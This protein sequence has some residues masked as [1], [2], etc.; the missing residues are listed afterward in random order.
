MI[1]FSQ[2]DVACLKE[3]FVWLA[4]LESAPVGL[5][6]LT[7]PR[8]GAIHFA[9]SAGRMP[10]ELPPRAIVLHAPDVAPPLGTISVA[11][12]SPRYEFAALTRVLE[13]F[14]A[15]QAQYEAAGRA[16]VAR[17]AR[18]GRNVVLGA[19]ATVEYGAIVG[20]DVVVGSNAF[21]GPGTIIGN[22]CRLATGCRVGVDGFG[23]GFDALGRGLQ[24]AHLGGVVCGEDVDVGA[25]TVVASGTLSATVIGAYS[26]L[27][28]LVYIGH[29][30]TIGRSVQVMGGGIVGG[31]CVIQDGA[32]LYP[33]AR[34]RGKITVGA[35]ATLGLS[36]TVMR[37]VSEG[38]VMMGD[39]ALELREG[40]RRQATI[41]SIVRSRLE[42]QK[43]S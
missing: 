20:D 24:I 9:Q 39:T 40:Q 12:A 29:N 18:I 15:G 26:K 10:A 2:Q 30:A 33:G 4:E 11:C 35:R 17:S 34:V 6:P 8:A 36:A 19:G 31:S 13:R 43:D 41:R 5:A 23:Y 1:E 27:D 22:G 25:N 28:A 3:K 37:S 38:E 32:V 42:E 14:R 16:Q 21:V 7:V